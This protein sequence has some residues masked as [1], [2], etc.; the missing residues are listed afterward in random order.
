MTGTNT[1]AD[2][3]FLKFFN[4]SIIEDEFVLVL[5]MNLILHGWWRFNMSSNA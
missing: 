1:T 5:H 3:F 2:R 4:T